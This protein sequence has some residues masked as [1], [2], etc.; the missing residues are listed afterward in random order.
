MGRAIDTS[1]DVSARAG[2]DDGCAPACDECHGHIDPRRRGASAR[3]GLLWAL[4]CLTLM[5][6]AAPAQAQYASGGFGAYRNSIVWFRW[7]NHLQNIP[8]TGVTITNSTAVDGQFLRV[9]CTLSSISGS[10]PNPDAIAYRPGAWA[11]DILDDLYH[12]GGAG[13]ANQLVVGLANRTDG[14][15]VFGNIACA[16]TFGPSNSVADPAY[17]LNGLVFA[18]AEQSNAGQNESVG[19]AWPLGTWRLIERASTCGQSGSTTTR[20]TANNGLTLGGASPICNIAIG[21]A[22]PAGIAFLDGST[23]FNFAVDGGGRSAIA[24]GVMVFIADQGDAPASYGN[25][26]HTPQFTFSGGV[27]PAG[28]AGLFSYPLATLQVPV[29]RLGATVD[30]EQGDLSN[31]AASGDDSDGVDDEDAVAA[32]APIALVPAANYTLGGV[33]C[34]GVGFVY[35]YI[36]FNR[37]GDFTDPGER[38]AMANCPGS[39]PISLAWTMPG[40]A[41]LVPGA[42]YMRLRIGAVD[43]QVNVPVGNAFS[44]EVEDHPVTLTMATDLA[45]TKTNTPGINGEVDQASDTVVSG[46]TTTYEIRVSNNGPNQ[47]TGARVR[48]TPVA[49][50]ACAPGNPVTISGDGV[51]AGGPFTVADLTGGGIALGLLAVG[52]TAVLGFTCNVL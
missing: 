9:T 47:V 26:L 38:S 39:G 2:A 45:I 5:L 12:I 10:G 27:P 46:S 29:L 49:G 36:D 42:S 28:T 11:G 20:N 7:G 40:P 19:A 43:A 52:G 50:L 4:L 8:N 30:V 34:A 35:G 44:G 24:L 22:G 33:Q 31:A 1:I 18:D 41:G 48:D 15:T 16:A 51:P 3:K 32:V 13:P 21:G 23:S 14:A 25:A 17:P 37:D 6:V